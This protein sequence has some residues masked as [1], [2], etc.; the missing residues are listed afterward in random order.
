MA[1]MSEGKTAALLFLEKEK[2]HKGK[3]PSLRDGAG[4]ASRF[5]MHAKNIHGQGETCN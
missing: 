5:P 1:I 2:E 3:L 4:S